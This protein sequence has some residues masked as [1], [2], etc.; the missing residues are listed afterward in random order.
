MRP[1]FGVHEPLLEQLVT[2]LGSEDDLDQ[3]IHSA[4]PF[5][6][7]ANQ[8]S[9]QLPLLFDLVWLGAAFERLFNLER[10]VG[11][12][13]G[14][15]LEDLFSEYPQSAAPAW[16]DLRGNEQTGSWI[17]R[18]AAEFYDHRSAIHLNPPRSNVWTPLEHGLVASVV[19]ELVVKRLLEQAG[20]FVPNERDQLELLAMDGRI[21]RDESGQF[22]DRWREAYK[23]A[24]S[25]R[26]KRRIADALSDDRSREELS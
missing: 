13:L 22:G 23:D 20:R 26:L 17:K 4:L 1:H 18:W 11:K 6:L 25:E 5:F 3:Q 15:E 9:E 7:M 8:L 16:K 12:Q 24:Q 2:G 21:R 10:S 19:F 14:T